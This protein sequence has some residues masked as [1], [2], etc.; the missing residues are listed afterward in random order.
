[1]D[2]RLSKTTPPA[3]GRRLLAWNTLLN[4][5][6]LGAPMVVAIVAT[7]LLI[8]GLGEER[9][10]VL[11]MAWA[12][13][14][15]F[16]IF[17]LG[18]GR[19]LT[20][21][22]AEKVGA[23]R[24]DDVPALT[25]TAIALTLLLGAVAALAVAGMTPWL[26]GEV[27]KIPG[28]LRREAAITFY[29]LA[30]SLPAVTSTAG[31]RGLLEAYQ[32]F[33]VVNAI[34]VPMGLLTFLGP[35]A[36][37]PFSTSLVPVVAVMVVG[38]TI[39]WAVHLWCC[40]RA[41]PELRTGLALD[42]ALLR[43]LLRFGGWMTASNVA[44]TFMVYLDRFVIG[45]VISMAA[46]TY[47][48]TPYEM[49]SRIGMLPGALLAAVF[50]A[51]AAS[52]AHDRAR[53]AAIFDWTVRAIFLVLFPM[54][55]VLVGLAYEGLY[56]W[57]GEEF[58]R[59]GTAVLQWIAVG[60]FINT[61]GMVPASGIQGAGRPDLTG[62]LNLVELPFYLVALWLLLGRFGIEGA[63]MAWVARVTADTL[64][65]FVMALRLE[66][67]TAASLRR[68]ALTIGA[69]L[70]VFALA[71]LLEGVV[72]KGA[73]LVT[74]LAAFTAAAWFLVLEGAERDEVRLR[75]RAAL[76]GWSGRGGPPLGPT[77]AERT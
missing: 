51:L 59:N 17:D 60:V 56:L 63:A 68:S 61:M 25:W 58:A 64:I 55:L 10:G 46:V 40:L 14:G 76:P 7:P 73:A 52:F 45:A 48:V 19:A 23:G 57:L 47:Y 4:L 32:R 16:S 50:P 75:L 41:V 21:L 9:F 72:L 67:T 15:Y 18:L 36:V 66:V 22:V 27:L 77:A 62:K 30:V 54:T 44:S 3:A 13:I 24:V 20:Q 26:T 28:P 71:A 2:P 12:L 11:T 38:R 35:L 34:R 8:R 53:T 1:V 5:V 74:L 43:P 65:L 49:V 37:L 29:L 31:L 70:P 39:A 6:G 42:R 69:A 33:G